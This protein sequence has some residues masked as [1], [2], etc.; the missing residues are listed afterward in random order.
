M[1]TQEH[2]KEAKKLLR[3]MERD[4]A[5]GDE[6]V[7]SEKLWRAASHAVKAVAEEREWPCGNRKE[8]RDAAI[9]LSEETGDGRYIGGFGM[10]EGFYHNAK[11]GWMEDFQLADRYLVREFVEDTVDLIAPGRERP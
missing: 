11:L 10:A 1:T 7:A 6:L 9:R 4:F 2:A 8:L 3:E 5:I